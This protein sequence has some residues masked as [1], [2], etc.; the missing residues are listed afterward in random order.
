MWSLYDSLIEP[1]PDDVPITQV[2]QNSTCTL[3]N[4]SGQTGA[5]ISNLLAAR[6]PLF[7]QEDYLSMS[8]RACASLIKS[9]NFAEASVGAAAL[10][11]YYNQVSKVSQLQNEHP[12]WIFFTN[13]NPFTD[14]RDAVSGKKIAF[15]GHFCH[16]GYASSKAA[17]SYI[18]E[19]EPQAGDYPDS[20]CEYILPHMDVVFITGFTFINKTLPRLLTLCAH[21][22][23]ILAGPSVCMAP[24]LFSMGVTE[25]AGTVID[26]F[27]T[28]K[29][30]AQCNEH[31]ILMREGRPLR[32]GTQKL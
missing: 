12:E 15:V 3:V 22:H 11:A 14:I 10:N 17:E 16:A 13:T 31:K 26:D 7:T 19:R 25:L 32:F 27:D 18:L 28:A 24:V 2:F 29:R 4:A 9:W 30:C 8:W 5:T 23:V 20:A 21:A 6:P 1:I